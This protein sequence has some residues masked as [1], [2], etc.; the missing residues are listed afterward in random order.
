MIIIKAS[1]D[2]NL[3]YFLLIEYIFDIYVALNTKNIQ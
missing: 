1:I 2:H 3:T